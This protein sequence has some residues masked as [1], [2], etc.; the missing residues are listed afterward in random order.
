[1]PPYV[2]ASIALV[3]ATIVVAIAL[4]SPRLHPSKA[5]T[6]CLVLMGLSGAIF[7]TAVAVIVLSMTASLPGYVVMTPAVAALGV[8]TALPL[9]MCWMASSD[10]PER[11]VPDADGSE[12]DDGGG[13]GG[14]GLRPEDEP[15][16]DPGPSDGIDWDSFDAERAGWDPTPA[17][18]GRDLVGV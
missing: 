1:V 6:I 17:L 15:P 5:G 2:H 16:R 4:P 13:G 14:G 3:A 7:L 18:P 8:A 9:A 12:D 11:V 10:A